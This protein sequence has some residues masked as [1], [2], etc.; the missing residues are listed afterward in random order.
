MARIA[1][2]PGS[3]DPI[4]KGHENLIRRALPLFDK[5][6][7]AIGVNADKKYMFSL[8]ERKEWIRQTFSFAENFEVGS[9][10]GLTVNYCRSVNANYII[11]GLRNAEDFQFESSIA[12]MNRE[13][14][15]EIDTVFLVTS[16]EYS[17]YSSSIVRDILRNDGD[18][19]KF[20]PNSIQL[21]DDL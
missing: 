15:A 12:Q 18:V 1:V 11:R 4:T 19:S 14:A 3:F 21:N 6:I 2:F 13:L 8:E 17:A 7:V 5:V 16:P 9:Y 10:E 20:I